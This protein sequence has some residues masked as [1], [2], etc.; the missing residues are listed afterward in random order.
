MLEHS[1]AAALL[2]AAVE[3]RR[4]EVLLPAAA[5]VAHQSG[6]LVFQ[7]VPPQPLDD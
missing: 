4:D 7:A 3:A 1:D 2:E 5:E 6:A